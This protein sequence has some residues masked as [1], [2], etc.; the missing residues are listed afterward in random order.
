METRSRGE[1]RTVRGMR[2]VLM[3]LGALAV[4]GSAS[5]AHADPDTESGGDDTAFLASLRAA[6]LTFASNEQAVVAA[7]AVCS[8]ANNGESGLKIVKQ[9]TTD[10]PGLDMDGAAQF[11]QLAASS[12][13]PHHLQ[14]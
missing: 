3:L 11:A 6:G 14:K 12:Y 4:I 8:M 7:H 13:C 5:P 9:L 2:G 1:L 10:N